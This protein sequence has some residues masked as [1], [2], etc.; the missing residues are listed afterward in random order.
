MGIGREKGE[1][2][3]IKKYGKKRIRRCIHNGAWFTEGVL[4]T[5][6]A[7]SLSNADMLTAIILVAIM[8]AVFPFTRILRRRAKA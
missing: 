8:L 3:M 4:A 6:V 2:D 1:V 7:F 5:L